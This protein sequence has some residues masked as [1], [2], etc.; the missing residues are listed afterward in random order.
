MKKLL[1]VLGF[2]AVPA[3]AD[4]APPI[5]PVPRVK[6]TAINGEGQEFSAT[7]IF[8][9]LAER[10]ALRQCERASSSPCLIKE[11]L[12][13]VVVYGEDGLD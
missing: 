7:R 11:C 5:A 8:R 1:C 12:S 2:L 10:T 3:F 4:F 9:R 13:T 6:C